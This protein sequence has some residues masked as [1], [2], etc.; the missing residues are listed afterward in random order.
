VFGYKPLPNYQALLFEMVADQVGTNLG[1]TQAVRAA[2]EASVEP[3]S[4]RNLLDRLEQPPE[5]AAPTKYVRERKTRPGI[6]WLEIESRNHS[7][8]RAGEISQ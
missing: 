6:N 7:L 8:G 4:V 2:V 1:L 3:P 5:P